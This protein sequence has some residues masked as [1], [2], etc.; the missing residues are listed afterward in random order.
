MAS[1]LEEL[2]GAL[3]GETLG[4]LAGALGADNDAVSK[5]VAAAL[6]AILGGLAR[7]SRQPEGAAAIS[8]A[9]GNDHDGSILDSLG[10]VFGGSPWAQQQATRHGDRI[11]G[12]VFGQSR[13]RVEQ[14][15][16]QSSGLSSGI[17]QK[18]LPLLA[19]IVMGY[20]G[21]KM[22]GGGDVASSLQQER[23]QVQQNDGMF[24]AILDML[25]G[26]DDNAGGG[27]L[28]DVA[29]DL[30]SGPAGRAILGQLLGGGR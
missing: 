25:D 26:D 27:G 16:Q 23:A 21:R 1:M 18:L 14:Q 9:L 11:L 17:V 2:A 19:P 13:P 22:R 30:L 3:G 6:P 12:H 28:M 4:Q 10:A 20:I 29:G 15:V 8:N 24:G 7:N 5:G